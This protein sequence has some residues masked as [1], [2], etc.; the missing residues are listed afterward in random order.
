MPKCDMIL[1]LG[2]TQLLYVLKDAYDDNSHYSTFCYQYQAC[3]L[4]CAFY[5]TM[6]INQSMYLMSWGATGTQQTR[7]SV[8]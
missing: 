3:S 6:P 5:T 2:G 8:Q 1:L 7:S 4:N